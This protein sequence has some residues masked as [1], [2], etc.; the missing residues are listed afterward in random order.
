MCVGGGGDGGIFLLFWI[1]LHCPKVKKKKERRR[2]PYIAALAV[3]ESKAG[4]FLS[5]SKRQELVGAACLELARGTALKGLHDRAAEKVRRVRHEL[6]RPFVRGAWHAAARRAAPFVQQRVAVLEG[7]IMWR[8]GCA[9]KTERRALFSPPFCYVDRHCTK[10]N[11]LKANSKPCNSNPP[12][13][14]VRGGGDSYR[15]STRTRTVSVSR[16][17]FKICAANKE[18]LFASIGRGPKRFCTTAKVPDRGGQPGTGHC[19]KNPDSGDSISD[20]VE[21]I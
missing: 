9:T 11:I 20:R 2:P 15:N 3:K 21:F 17:T 6:A 12:S 16:T 5:G 7:L 14:V 19:E 10:A 1:Q 18:V 13:F 4:S 8:R